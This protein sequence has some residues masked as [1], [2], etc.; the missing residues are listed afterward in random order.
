MEGE[1]AYGSGKAGVAFDPIVYVKKPQVIL[2]LISWVRYI[3]IYVFV[4]FQCL[5]FPIND[6]F[7][8]EHLV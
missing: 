8:S 1:G 6:V 2:R 5:M 4:H 7:S 3:I